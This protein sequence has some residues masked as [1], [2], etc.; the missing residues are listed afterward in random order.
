MDQ[1]VKRKPQ[2]TQ[3]VREAH[4]EGDVP[5]EASF[6]HLALVMGLLASDSWRCRVLYKW[7]LFWLRFCKLRLLNLCGS[8]QKACN[9]PLVLGLVGCFAEPPPCSQPAATTR[10]SPPPPSPP[11]FCSIKP[12][13][14]FFPP[15]N[16]K[17]FREQIG[18]LSI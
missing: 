5:F 8:S 12:K 14:E 9:K 1:R 10:P 7:T 18:Q 11:S 2:T 15:I 17:L 13:L 4:L 16:R 6:F 3:I